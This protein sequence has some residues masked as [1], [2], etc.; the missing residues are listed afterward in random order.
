[1]PSAYTQRIT[2]NR[3]T[4]HFASSF[5]ATSTQ[6]LESIQRDVDI[7]EDFITEE[8]EQSL[9]NEVELQLKRLRYEK[10]H[11]DDVSQIYVHYY[12]Q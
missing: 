1:M 9:V 5:D 7:V 4:H 3:C 2:C 11:W 6:T 12:I 8:E 10:D